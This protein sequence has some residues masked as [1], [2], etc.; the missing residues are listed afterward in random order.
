MIIVGAGTTGAGAAVVIQEGSPT[1]FDG[2]VTYQVINTQMGINDAGGFA[3]GCD[4]SAGTTVDEIVARY[5]PGGGFELVAREGTQ[6]VGQAPG[7]G[8]G[9]T[10]DAAHILNDATAAAMFRSSALTGATTQT[11][12]F[13]NTSVSAGTVLVQTDTTVPTGQLVAPDQ[14]IDT[15]STD[16][17]RSD[18]LGTHMIYHGDLNGPTATDLVM[19]YD[20]AVVA[21]EGAPLPG[22]AF[23]EN[24]TTLGS[25]A[26]SQ[27]VSPYNGHYIFRGANI[28]T[29]V[30]WVV[31]DGQVVAQTDAP[32]TPGNTELYDDAIFTATFFNGQV[33]S[34]GDYVIGG[35]TTAADLNA[36]AVLVLNGRTVIAREGDLV[37]LDGDGVGEPN[38]A[39]HVFNDED[40]F[41]TDDRKYYFHCDL[42][43]PAA[44]TVAVGQALLWMQLPRPGDMNCDG[45]I[46][47]FDIDGFLLALFDPA[48]YDATYPNCDRGNADVDDSGA[49]DFFDIDPFIDLLF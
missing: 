45:N 20:G 13:K 28:T 24:V 14:S 33:N 10:S 22:G 46:D 44:P 4:T 32:I 7:I 25:N 31:V 17:F 49:V 43:D 11:A 9:S 39:L 2:T 8:Y 30:D 26:G 35:V 21:Q 19:V 42:R 23:A 36:N 34:G 18:A 29:L 5:T 1:F 27:N 3:F 37:D 38:L 16:R 6:A 41:L 15:L 47:F 12:L 48:A 40:S